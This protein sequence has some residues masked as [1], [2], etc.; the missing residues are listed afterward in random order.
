M[1]LSDLF[2]AEQLDMDA[3]LKTARMKPPE[4][5]RFLQALAKKWTEFVTSTSV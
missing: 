3:V 2:E 1:F 5:K 4:V